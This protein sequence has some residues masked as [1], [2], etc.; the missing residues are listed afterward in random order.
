[1]VEEGAARIRWN[2]FLEISHKFM[3]S[4]CARVSFLDIL[5]KKLWHRCYRVNFAKFLRAPTLQNTSGRLLLYWLMKLNA[6]KFSKKI[7]IFLK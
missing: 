1:M 4:I 2:V 5:K 6:D 3:E 7:S